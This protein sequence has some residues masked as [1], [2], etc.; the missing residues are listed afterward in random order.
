MLVSNGIVGFVGSVEDAT[1]TLDF[2]D[3]PW[4]EAAKRLLRRRTKGGL[5][6]ALSMQHSQY[7]FHGAVLYNDEDHTVVVRRPEELA[8]IVDL[9]QTSSV[10]DIVR[11]AALI[12]HAF[13]NQH[14]PVEVDGCC[15]L[16]PM[17]S[18]E[19]LMTKTVSDLKLGELSLRF[20]R[21]RLGASRPLL[22][23]GLTHE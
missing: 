11:Q 22:M 15:I 12:G 21:V 10:P 14:V 5:D 18:S 16:M 4:A 17:L 2:I 3:V 23:T 1:G 9:S 8:L 13:G 19:D 20:D 6:F 7:L